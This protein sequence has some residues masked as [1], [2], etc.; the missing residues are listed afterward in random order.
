MNFKITYQEEHY[1][2]IGVME[3]ELVQEPSEETP[4]ADQ[5]APLS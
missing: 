2:G 5:S 4:I 3:E 1:L